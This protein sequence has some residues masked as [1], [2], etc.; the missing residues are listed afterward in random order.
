MYSVRG[1]PARE[2]IRR[3]SR[4]AGDVPEYVRPQLQAG[5]TP[6]AAHIVR[7]RRRTQVQVSRVS[8]QVCVQLQ[9]EKTPGT[10]AQ[11]PSAA[12]NRRPRPPATAARGALIW[13]PRLLSAA[14]PLPADT[15]SEAARSVVGDYF[16]RVPRV[17]TLRN[18]SI[19]LSFGN[20]LNVSQIDFRLKRF[21]DSSLN[22]YTYPVRSRVE[23]FQ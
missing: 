20:V 8:A 11:G 16:K 10:R 18:V 14:T 3:R 21:R 23:K 1:A 7:V 2:R 19:K 9:H 13:P 22:L 5:G 4:L 15:A 6:E 17:H 12:H